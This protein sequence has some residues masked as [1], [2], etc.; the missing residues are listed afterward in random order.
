MLLGQLFETLDIYPKET[1]KEA[2]LKVLNLTLKD[3]KIIIKL[4]DQQEY[5]VKLAD[6]HKTITINELKQIMKLD[7]QALQIYNQA[8][9][10]YFDEND[11]NDMSNY[12]SKRLGCVIF[13]INPDNSILTATNSKLQAALVGQQLIQ[14]GIEA[15]NHTGSDQQFRLIKLPNINVNVHWLSNQY[16]Q[17]GKVVTINKC[18]ANQRLINLVDSYF[19]Q[20]VQKMIVIKRE[21]PVANRINYSRN[22]ELALVERTFN[23]ATSKPDLKKY[24]ERAGEK[25]ILAFGI[26]RQVNEIFL[27]NF[28]IQVNRL[29][30]NGIYCYFDRK[31][32]LLTVFKKP[33]SRQ[34]LIQKE[35]QNLAEKNNVSIG[36]SNSFQNKTELL[37]A[38][39]QAD[40][41]IAND[42]LP[43]QLQEFCTIAPAYLANYLQANHQLTLLNPEI[44]LLKQ[45]DQKRQSSYYKTLLAYLLNNFNVARTAKQLNVHHNTV[46]Y[47]LGQ[48]KKILNYSLDDPLKNANLYLSLILA[49]YL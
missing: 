29:F 10:K 2:K 1:I 45:Y 23:S 34:K 30:T 46:L 11:L 9:L 40:L 5:D 22:F 49:Q 24:L 38:Y 19:V 33:F 27:D 26:K 44:K 25:Y 17:I 6:I 7:Y 36:V 3:G 42:E 4:A 41:A 28:L 21:T 20:F 13:W 39:H 31:L 16:Q 43:P 37:T 8:I 48:V 12:L 15:A 47:R 32:F 18:D 35:L 14:K